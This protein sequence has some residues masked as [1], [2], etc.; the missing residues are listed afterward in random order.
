MTENQEEVVKTQESEQADHPTLSTPPVVESEMTVSKGLR[1]LKL[2]DKRIT[3]G[4]VGVASIPVLF[5]SAVRGKDTAT[6]HGKMECEEAKK[7]FKK[8]LQSA[9]DLIARRAQIKAAI[10]NSNAATSVTIGGKKMSVAAAIERKNSIGYDKQLLGALQS[11]LSNIE[12]WMEARNLDVNKEL[13]R[14]IEANASSENEKLLTAV[15]GVTQAYR[16]ENELK[17]FDPINIRTVI[18]EMDEEIDAFEAEVDLALT[19]SNART[20]IQLK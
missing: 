18:T 17:I 6:V 5:V 12:T 4:T 16:E 3:K 19:E 14:I 10:V 11:S 13:A 2:L 1:E 9:R 15:E 20:L 7:L 8:N